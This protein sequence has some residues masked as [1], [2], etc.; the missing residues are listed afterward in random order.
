MKKLICYLR[1]STEE[2][3]KTKNGLEA[4]EMACIRFANDNGYT[5]VEVVQEVAS[6]A[7]DARPVLAEAMAK[8]AKCENTYLVVNKLDRLSRD[9]AF[10]LN[11]MKKSKR[12]IVTEIGEEV[13]PFMLHIYAVLAEKERAMISQRTKAALAAKK[14]RGESVGASKEVL[15]VATAISAGVNARKADEFATKLG[16]SLS[17]MRAEGMTLQRIADELNRNGTRTA[18][19]GVWAKATVKGV[20][21]RIEKFK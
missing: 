3:G 9:A 18:R 17:R 15:T 5:V 1:V 10:I 19:G 12:F 6:G 7:L 11:L 13:D 20:L 4:Q 8:V 2:Q 14:A 21:D 16:P